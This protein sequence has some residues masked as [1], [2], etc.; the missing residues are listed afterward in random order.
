[1]A[2]AANKQIKSVPKTSPKQ[3]ADTEADEAAPPPKKKGGL[4][5][6]LLLL[7][8]LLGG[9]GGGAW[10]FFGSQHAEPEGKA[11]GAKSANA[12]HASTKPPVFVPLDAFTVN[13][14]DEG[15]SSQYLQVGLVLK[16][17]DSSFVDA[18]KLHMPEIRNRVLL[19]LSGKRASQIS[20]SEGKNTLSAELMREIVQ[21][22]SAS[23]PAT[24]LDSV[25][26][27]S[28]VIQ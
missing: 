14:Q 28:F 20:T 24:G 6:I 22:L 19:L 26:F 1:M 25:L 23:V 5:K 27:T 17:N 8:L 10:Y 12:K 11:A 18:V 4:L 2:T 16:V 7:T 13:L 3:D 15:A 9:A 21:P